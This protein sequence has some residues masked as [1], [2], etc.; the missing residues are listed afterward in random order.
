MTRALTHGSLVLVRRQRR[1]HRNRP[2]FRREPTR[3]ASTQA[4]R[5]VSMS[6]FVLLI[7][8]AVLA[9]TPPAPQPPL[10]LERIVSPWVAAPDYKIADVDG[11]TGLHEQANELGSLVRGDATR[12]AE[13]DPLKRCRAL[14]GTVFDLRIVHSISRL[15]SRAILHCRYSRYAAT[16]RL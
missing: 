15:Q 12:H 13:H 3:I 4:I 14:R 6:L 11:D 2:E 8:S 7:P 1:S 5:R 9:Q 10:V 16:R